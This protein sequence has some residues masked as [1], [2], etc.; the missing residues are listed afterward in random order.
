MSTPK[1]ILPTQNLHGVLI[2]TAKFYSLA[3]QNLG[4]YGTEVRDLRKRFAD[5]RGQ[6]PA[7][8]K[9]QPDQNNQKKAQPAVGQIGQWKTGQNLHVLLKKIV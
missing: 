7:P 8:R 6:K 5:G 2:F 4:K 1:Q 9:I 3:F